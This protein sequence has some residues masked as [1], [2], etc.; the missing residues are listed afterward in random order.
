MATTYPITLPSTGIRKV[1]FRQRTA[2]AGYGSPY[3]GIQQVHAHPL[4]MWE[5]TVELKPMQRSD[6]NGAGDWIGALLS[7]NGPYGSFYLGD[8]GHT[9]ARGV[10]TGTPLVKGASQTGNTLLTDGWTVSQTG[11][12]KAGDWVQVGS[13]STRQLVNVVADTNSDVSGNATLEI[14]PRI[15]TAF[16]D[17]TAL[18]VSSP[19]GVWRLTEPLDFS[20]EQDLFT[21]G[22][23][24]T[25]N[26][27]F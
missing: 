8:P 13:G 7:L 25:A 11:I 9:T 16:A 4:Q 27:A 12:L 1:S 6:T 22:L 10:A 21:R 2:V 3:T 14:W 5:A 26:E 18:T 23:T 17:N 19:T 24:F 15:R 20:W